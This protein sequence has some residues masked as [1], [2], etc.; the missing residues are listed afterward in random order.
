M[1]RLAQLFA[2]TLALAL[3]SSV[4]AQDSLDFILPGT[5]VRVAVPELGFKTQ[6]REL[7]ATRGC[8]HV[9]LPLGGRGTI[10]GVPLHRVTRLEVAPYDAAVLAGGV[11][12]L[13]EEWIVL[14]LDRVRYEH[15]QRCP[16]PP[17]RDV[18]PLKIGPGGVY[19]TNLRR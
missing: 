17:F 12:S 18:T 2:F 1:I 11:I 6:I 7:D 4:Q 15:D 8:L 9:R 14:D 19:R 13:Q 10:L 3:P 16:E 5:R